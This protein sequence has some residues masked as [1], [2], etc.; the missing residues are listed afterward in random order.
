METSE[1][2]AKRL[3]PKYLLNKLIIRNE[4]LFLSSPQLDLPQTPNT[5]LPCEKKTVKAFWQFTFIKSLYF[6][7]HLVT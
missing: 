3:Q 4:L 6:F 5:H 7:L 2:R 1:E